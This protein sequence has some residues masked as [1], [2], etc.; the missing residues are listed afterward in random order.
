M[1]DRRA[2]FDIPAGRGSARS[3]RRAVA[4]TLRMWAL[5][6][7]L[8]DAELVVSELMTNAVLHAAGTSTYELSILLHD[9]R[10]RLAV[11]DPSAAPPR[12]RP[13]DDGLPGGRGLRIVA[14]L[15]RSWGHQATADGGKQV[16]AELDVADGDSTP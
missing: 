10:L 8:A 15:A 12:I 4:V 5:E 3:A 11:T 9:G 2:T 13:S 16:W 14:S 6:R 1:A 7:L